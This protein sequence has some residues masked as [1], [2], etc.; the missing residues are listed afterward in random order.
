MAVITNAFQLHVLVPQLLSSSFVQTNQTLS[1]S[2]GDP[3]GGILTTQDIASFVIQTSTNLV[4]WASAN[5]SIST[6]AGG[7]LSF[8]VPVPTNDG[9]GFYRVLSQ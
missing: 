4:D 7:G 3:G 5:P 2:F 1:I 8:Q 9:A 6:N